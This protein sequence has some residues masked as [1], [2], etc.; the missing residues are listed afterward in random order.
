MRTI[1]R[2]GTIVT[3]DPAIGDLERGDILIEEGMIVDIAP[4]I[5][6]PG[7]EV[8][9][10]TDRI[11]IPGLIDNHRHTWQTAFRGIGAE[12]TFSEWAHALHRT[13]KPRYTPDDVYIGTLYGRLKHCTRE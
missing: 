12:W 3:L 5:D 13:L 6:V 2:G 1:I 8:I 10:A 11:V 4:H 7:T 9:D